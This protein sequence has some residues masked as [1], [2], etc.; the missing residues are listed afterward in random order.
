M[1]FSLEYTGFLLEAGDMN[2]IYYWHYDDEFHNGCCGRPNVLATCAWEVYPVD[3]IEPELNLDHHSPTFPLVGGPSSAKV[4]NR[5]EHYKGLS[6]VLLGAVLWGVS[7][8]AAQV[9]FQ[10]YGF[11]PGWLVTVRMTVSGFLLLTG[12]AIVQGPQHIFAIWRDKRDVMRLTLLS[13]V[14][15]L[16]VQYSYFASIRYGNAAAATMLQYLGPIFLTLYVALRTRRMPSASQL[17][18][19]FLALLGASLLVTDGNWQRFSVSPLA[20]VWGLISA[21]TAAFYTAYPKRLVLKYGAAT[22]VGWGMLIGG[23][24]MSFLTP[25]WDFSG[26]SSIGT[27]WLVSFVVLFGTLIAFYV[28]IASLK[29]ISAAEA[30]ILGSGEPLSA[31]LVA[32]TFL[33]VHMGIPAMIGGLCIVVTVT[34]LARAG[35]T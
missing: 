7:G 28:Y 15:L 31:A 1:V 8:T 33:H 24:G 2:V 26:R 9:L 11:N 23:V 16:A 20:V 34:I 14:G 21:L 6:M 4:G 13:V 19:V 10:R 35:S 27:W 30:S 5:F 17:L 12:L 3:S 29:Y 25:P 32:V 22:I 18:A